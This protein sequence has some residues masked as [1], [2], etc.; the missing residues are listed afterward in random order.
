[1]R[2]AERRRIAREMHDVLAHRLSLLSVHAG[3]LEFRPDGAA[4]DIAR[5]A[6][7]IRTSAAD[8]LHDLRQVITVL[9]EDTSNG[10]GPPQPDFGQ[11]ADL[12]AES[13]S[14]GMTIEARITL[15]DERSLP[16]AAGRTAYRVVQEGLTNARKHAPGA[17]VEV[18]VTTDGEGG[19]VAEV[20]SGC[21]VRLPGQAAPGPSHPAGADPVR[22][23]PGTGAGL[24]GL[25]ER[26][27][28]AGGQ[29][30]HGHVPGGGFALRAT[31]PASA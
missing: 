16:A 9:R 22:A 17:P 5:A 12:L 26:L 1:V 25:A 2:E 19:L 3:A 24:I 13:R 31:I 27:E 23:M 15:P 7:V 21:S 20:I 28:L 30:E 14:A 18:T 10:T 29:L 6:A 8:A 11:L 4:T